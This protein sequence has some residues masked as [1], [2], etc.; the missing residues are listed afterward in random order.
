MWLERL[1][2]HLVLG[3]LALASDLAGAHSEAEADADNSGALSAKMEPWLQATL[4]GFNGG[5]RR[6]DNECIIGFVNFP[7]AG[8][9]S[10]WKQHF[11]LQQVTSLCH[12]FPRTFLA[13]LV[14]PNRAGDLRSSASKCLACL[15]LPAL[16]T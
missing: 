8:V 14:L 15:A 9:V 6:A 5:I 11:A 10:P 16:F 12:A 13:V 7:V 3:F 2:E 1:Q 4:A